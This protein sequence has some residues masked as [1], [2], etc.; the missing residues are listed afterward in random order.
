MIGFI[1]FVIKQFTTMLTFVFFS[2]YFGFQFTR[3]FIFHIYKGNYYI[4]LN[5]IKYKFKYILFIIKLFIPGLSVDNSW[6]ALLSKPNSANTIDFKIPLHG[7][8][9]YHWFES[10]YL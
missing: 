6:Q 4:K 10:L 5:H 9:R 7:I 3:V 8:G 1:S 2:S